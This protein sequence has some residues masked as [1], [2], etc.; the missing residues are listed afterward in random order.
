MAR[1]RSRRRAAPSA[2]VPRVPEQAIRGHYLAIENGDFARRA[3]Y[4]STPADLELVAGRIRDLAGGTRR[5]RVLLWAHGGLVG[6]DEAARQTL[7][8]KARFLPLGVY[9]LH[10]IWHTAF[11]EEVS[12]LLVRKHDRALGAPSGPVPGA[13]GEPLEQVSERVDEAIEV[14]ARP[15]GRPIWREMKRDARRATVGRGGVP[16]PAGRLLDAIAALGIA[17]EFHLVGHSAGAVFHSLL[18]PGFAARGLE[19]RSL[20]LLAPSATTALFRGRVIPHADE[21]VKAVAIH[22]MTDADEQD[23]HVGNVPLTG[24]PIYRKS[25]LFLVSNSFEEL[26]RRR[27]LGLARHIDADRDGRT[28]DRDAAVARWVKES[29]LCALVY[30]RP[31]RERPTDTLHGVFD[32]DPETLR[33]LEERIAK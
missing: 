12:D 18:V 8:L 15:I 1:L 21:T 31:E 24:A 27:L 6:E 4:P 3:I 2:P 13:L 29:G 16:G 17:V 14:L 20:S 30:R 28:D 19:V 10:F 23:D 33:A 11:L 7:D 5:A 26:H 25:M 32:R 9:P 22:T